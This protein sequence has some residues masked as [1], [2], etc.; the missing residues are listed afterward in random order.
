MIAVHFDGAD[1][2]YGALPESLVKLVSTKET[3][4]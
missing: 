4:S 3:K 1:R 2:D